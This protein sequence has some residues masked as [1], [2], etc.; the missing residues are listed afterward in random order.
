M[1]ALSTANLRRTCRPFLGSLAIIMALALLSVS[2]SPTLRS[3]HAQ[4]AA[5]ESTQATFPATGTGAIPDSPGGTPPTYGTPLVLSYAVTGV[6]APLGTVS[7]S[8]TLTHTWVGDLDMVLAA[9]GGSPNMVV[10]GHVGAIAAADFGD[11]SNYSGT[12][13]FADSAPSTAMANIWSVATGTNG[14]AACGDACNV[15]PGTYR[16]TARGGAGQTNPAPVTSLNTTFGGLTT[17]QI[18]GTWTLTIRDGGGGDTGSVTAS[19]LSLTSSVALQ[20]IVD[21]DG[22][23][24]TDPSVVRNTGGGPSGQRTWFNSLSGGGTTATAWGLASDELVPADYDGDNKT[25]IA[26]WREGPAGAAFFYILKSTT[27]TLQ[28]DNFGQ[29]G[30]D[31][32]VVGDYDGDNKDDVAV[33]R[34]GASAGA[35]SFWYYRSSVNGIIIGTQWGDNGDFPAPGDYDGDNKNDYVVQRNGGGGTAV[36]FF[37]N[38]TSG[39]STIFFGTPTDVIVP[40]D[41]DADGKTDIAVARGSGG[42]ILWFVRNSSTSATTTYS[43]GLSATDLLTQGDW[44]GDGKTD[45]GVW[46]PNADPTQNYFYWLRSSDGVVAAFEWGQNGDVPPFSNHH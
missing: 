35:K 23:G 16:T 10:V 41:Y 42:A 31:P 5:P 33:Y 6:N 15:T 18:N 24:K 45:I 39:V 8:I 40:G 12:Y 34:A 7:L 11:S 17:G 25:D 29:T 13:V 9:P 21:Y 3:A 37:N 27:G 46:R 22:D 19:S 36:F 14:N 26:V 2:F 28:S 44:D 4:K 32:T 30:D 1:R 20:H 38:T 43:F